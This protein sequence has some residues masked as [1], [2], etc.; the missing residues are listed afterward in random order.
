MKSKLLI[1]IGLVALA[2]NVW[3]ASDTSTAAVTIEN[4]A[5]TLENLEGLNFGT[6]LPFGR[7]GS[8]TVNL[9]GQASSNFAFISDHTNVTVSR[10]AVTGVPGAPYSVVLPTSAQTVSNGSFEM[11]VTNFTRTAGTTLDSAGNDEFLVGATLQ[12]GANQPAGDYV[13]E[14]EVT[15]AYN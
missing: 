5:I 12:V 3:A 6:V 15:V 10:W 9:K 1:A 13:G 14:F 8:V 7:N 11:N 4:Q 2:G